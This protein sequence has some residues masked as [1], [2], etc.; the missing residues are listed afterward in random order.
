MTEF[1]PFP[2]IPRLNRDM[3]ITEKIDGCNAAVQIHRVDKMNR[4]SNEDGSLYT[5][6]DPDHGNAILTSDEQFAV[7]PQ[8]R[9]RFITT[10]YDNHG[11][12]QWVYER[13]DELAETLGEGTH[14]GEFWGGGIQ[15]GYGLPKGEKRFSLFNT[16]RW[17]EENTASVLGLSA[18]PVLYEG[19]FD[20]IV[21]N[22]WVETLRQLGSFASPGFM[23]PEGVIVFH[24]AA[25]S[26]F[27]V[28]CE[29]DEQPKGLTIKGAQ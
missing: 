12:A 21:V 14:F 18:V 7:F 3:V 9:N 10:E 15:R 4:V 8:S 11:F 23:R 2:K 26:M 22:G 25:N 17:N 5:L 6:I 13:A 28:T 1:T 20:S 27:K 16:S 19:P 29:K 24:T